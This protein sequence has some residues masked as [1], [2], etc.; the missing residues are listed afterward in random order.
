MAKKYFDLALSTEPAADSNGRRESP[1]FAV[2]SDPSFFERVRNECANLP[3]NIDVSPTITMLLSQLEATEKVGLA[4]ILLVERDGKSIDVEGLRTLRLGFPQV[5]PIAIVEFCDQ[6]CELRL[7]SIGVYSIMLPPFDQV[8]IVRELERV[9]PNVPKFK[10]HPDLMKRGQIRLDFLI[11]SDLTY[12]LGINYEVSMLLK[13]FGFS[14]QD[15]RINIPLACDEAITNAIV[16]GNRSSPDKK[17]NVQIYISNSRFRIRVRDQGAGFDAENVADPREGDN[18]HRS[19]G[20][21]IFLMRRIMDSVLFKEEGRV[22]E[23]EKRNS[24]SR[25][26]GAPS[27]R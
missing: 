9:A 4:Y 18:I 16:H 3:P 11:P 24:N 10:R 2:V 17:V 12:V 26:N 25:R 5:V 19:S 6:Q 20:R 13:E 8:D 7:Q 22:I 1:V 14:Q 21:G 23:L 15:A 27:E